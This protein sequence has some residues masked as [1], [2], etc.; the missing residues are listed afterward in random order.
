MVTKRKAKGGAPGG[1]T[2]PWPI[3]EIIARLGPLH[4]PA[5]SPRDYDPVSELVYTILS[6]HTSD[7]NSVRAY[8]S[9]RETF[10]EWEQVIKA[11]ADEIAESIRIGGLVEKDDRGDDSHN[12]ERHEQFYQREPVSPSASRGGPFVIERIWIHEG[13]LV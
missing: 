6:Q 8:A 1:D 13:D 2:G 11:D 9:L 7:T 5:Q 10:K 12:P 4:G 3:K